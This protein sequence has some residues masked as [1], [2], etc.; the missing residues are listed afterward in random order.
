MTRYG[1]RLA[2]T[3]AVFAVL[4]VA[5]ITRPAKRL[6]DFDQI[7]YLNIAYDLR[8]HGVFSNSIFDDV[9]S[10]QA[11]P[12]SGMFFTPIYP[13]IVFAAG[14]LDSRFA[15]TID[16]TI[17][18]DSNHRDL[19]T[20]DTYVLPLHIGHAIF[21]AIGVIAIAL[22]GELIFARRRVF[23]LAGLLATAGVV[24]EAELFSFLM[25]ES[26]AFCLFSVF[27]FALVRALKSSRPLAWAFAGAA[28][29][30]GCLTRPSYLVLIPLTLVLMAAHA[31]WFA[32]CT[33]RRSA[34]HMTAFLVAVFIFI[35]PWLLRNA[36]SVGKLRFTE[37]YGSVTLIE[38][39]A[40]NQMTGREYALAFPFCVP[41]IG[42]ALVNRFAGDDAMAR[43]QWNHTG[44]FF[45]LGRGRRNALIETH[46][47]LDPIIGDLVRTEMQRD[48]WRYVATSIPLAWCGLW[49]SDIWS[50]VMLP[51]FAWACV[52]AA[53]ANRPLLLF[54]ALPPLI[55]VGV[56]GIVAN[57]YPRYN[58]ALI[59]PIAVG[60]AWVIVRGMNGWRR[61]KAI[62]AGPA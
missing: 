44:S 61:R 26:I 51:L 57:H 27:G 6:N 19:A 14:K 3:L 52:S 55:L 37:E 20:C 13:L 25:T 32:P 33:L 41:V 15:S 59:G 2:F 22:T 47:R 1:F 5:I 38:R 8:H 18:A 48:G 34:S 24:V 45:E 50:V 10:T 46:K 60:A 23:F 43:F 39:F 31:L 17:E 29:G 58:L 54:Y 4:A 21:L 28:L 49:V 53:R 40:Y 30:L 9:D 36:V 56:H 11:V 12:P 42:P 16:C 35:G 62:T 7:F